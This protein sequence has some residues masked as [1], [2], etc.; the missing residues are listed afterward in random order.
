MPATQNRFIRVDGGF[1]RPTTGVGSTAETNRMLGGQYFDETTDEQVR[2]FVPA[3]AAT[4]SNVPG[5]PL[6][7]AQAPAG[8]PFDNFNLLLGDMLNG[9]KGLGTADLLKKKR[10]LERSALGR[11]SE[12]TPEEERVL[13]PSQQAAIRSGRTGALRPEID[14]NAYELEKAENSVDNFFKVFGEAKKLGAEWADKMVAQD[15]VIENAKKVIE[16]DSSKMATVLAGFNDKSKEKILGS[17]DYSKMKDPLRDLELENKRLA[18]EKLRNEINPPSSAS[19]AADQ[20]S[21][22]QTTVDKAIELSPASG[23]SGASKKVGDLLI[24]DT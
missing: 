11:S 12:I 22:L 2:N 19:N 23:A 6:P 10:A 20:L 7:S 24:G 18:N 14:E 1:E 15:S 21:F 3:P 17:L 5:S 4:T 13:S 9:A 16:A 8:D